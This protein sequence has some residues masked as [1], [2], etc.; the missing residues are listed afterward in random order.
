MP[1]RAAPT[2]TSQLR[3][4]II[5]A[6][7]IG[8]T[9]AF[10]LARDGGHRVTVVARPGSPRLAQLQRDG[11]I[12]D[13]EGAR[14]EVR[15]L[16]R[17]DED[18]AYDLAIVT[19]LAHQVDAILPALSRSAATCIQF[20]FNTF[21]PM[22]LESA[23]GRPRCTFGMPFVQAQ[24]D[25]DGKLKATIGAGGQ[26]TLIGRQQ[27]VDMFN[28]AGLPAAFEPNMPL[29]LR[30]HAPLCV[31]FESVSIA[32]MERGNGASWRTAI[33]LSQGVHASFDLIRAMGYPIYPRSK[34]WLDRSPALALAGTL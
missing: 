11:A 12:I 30:C 18:T 28:A 13:V 19:L 32:G 25:A 6:G 15:V 34:R 4:V 21:D 27:W 23:V 26:K 3:I 31:A 22:R 5:G 7:Q 8:S 24:L 33:S 16:D 10:K 20:M 9:F 17:L 14:A 1:Q 2:S 29:W